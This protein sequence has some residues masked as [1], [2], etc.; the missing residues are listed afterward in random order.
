MARSSASLRSSP[1]SVGLRCVANAPSL[2]AQFIFISTPK[3]APLCGLPWAI[4][5]SPR[6]TGLRIRRAFA[7]NYSPSNSDLSSKGINSINSTPKHGLYSLLLAVAVISAS[8]RRTCSRR[9]AQTWLFLLL[10]ARVS[11]CSS[12]SRSH[13]MAV[14]R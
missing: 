7:R 6:F 10:P 2:R 4:M 1:L 3:A 5:L 11:R 13:W 12:D 8:M 9:A 14:S